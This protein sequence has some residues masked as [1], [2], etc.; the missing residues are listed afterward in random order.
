[1]LCC[2]AGRFHQC[3][4]AAPPP[5]LSTSHPVETTPTPGTPGPIETTPTPG[6]PGP[7]ETTPKPP[8]PGPVEPTPE[9]GSEEPVGP[10]EIIYYPEELDIEPDLSDDEGIKEESREPP[11]IATNIRKHRITGILHTKED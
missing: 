1:M 9:P 8:T 2:T 4:T 11:K 5:T 7:I 10:T 6:T 3:A